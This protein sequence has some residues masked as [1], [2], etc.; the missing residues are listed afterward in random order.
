MHCAEE[1]EGSNMSS[2]ARV[3][4]IRAAPVMEFV[5][6]LL[7]PLRHGKRTHNAKY[8]L[9]FHTLILE[10]LSV[11]RVKM[12]STAFVRFFSWFT[13]ILIMLRAKTVVLY[14]ALVTYKSFC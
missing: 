3:C 4:A 11:W 10:S 13:L 12:S 14:I 8:L 7:Y 1:S 6:H 5:I 2:M 9:I